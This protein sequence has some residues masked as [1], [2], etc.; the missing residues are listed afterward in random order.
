SHREDSIPRPFFPD[1]HPPTNPSGRP[2]KIQAAEIIPAPNPPKNFNQSG[3]ATATSA[4][5]YRPHAH[6]GV[7]H[8]GRKERLPWNGR[9]PARGELQR[10]GL[11]SGETGRR[12]D[13]RREP[14]R[15]CGPSPWRGDRQRGATLRGVGRGAP[16]RTLPAGRGR[17]GAG[18]VR[19][20]ALD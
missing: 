8:A 6:G 7:G 10:G 19:A 20:E 16:P 3:L 15:G 13:G 5:G 2:W 18:S 14:D 1:S 11:A 17:R 4:G 12:S 9:K